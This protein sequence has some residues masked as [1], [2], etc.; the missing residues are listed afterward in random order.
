M[1]EYKRRLYPVIVVYVI[2]VFTLSMCLWFFVSLQHLWIW[3]I[4][5][6]L[7]FS[8]IHFWIRLQPDLTEHVSFTDV[9]YFFIKRIK[10]MGFFSC[11]EWKENYKNTYFKFWF[12]FIGNDKHF[13]IL[14]SIFKMMVLMFSRKLEKSCRLGLTH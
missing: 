7:W 6:D 3:R 14:Y 13:I 8:K 11:C 10:F 4:E 9:F 2:P 1:T 5:K 12:C